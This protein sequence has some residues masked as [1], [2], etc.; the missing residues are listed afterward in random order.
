MRPERSTPHRDRRSTLSP[1][2]G[3]LSNGTL[4]AATRA[5]A[6]ADTCTSSTRAVGLEALAPC[7]TS[8]GRV[9]R[10]RRRLSSGAT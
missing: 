6:G 8:G 1:T 10:R 2:D 3:L 4:A 5:I 9:L 7:K